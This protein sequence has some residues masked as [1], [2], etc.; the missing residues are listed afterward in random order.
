MLL[1][2][3]RVY[4]SKISMPI[5]RLG[6]YDALSDIVCEGQEALDLGGELAVM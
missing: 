1:W 4:F 5:V 3:P 2:K 6:T